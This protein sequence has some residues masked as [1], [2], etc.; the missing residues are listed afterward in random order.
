[1][2]FRYD[3]Y[4]RDY[5]RYQKEAKRDA[6]RRK[7]QKKS[8][9][10]FLILKILLVLALV[11]GTVYAVWRWR[12][13]PSLPA[14]QVT[15]STSADDSANADVSAEPEEQ[16]ADQAAD[17]DHMKAEEA[18]DAAL[19]ESGKLGDYYIEITGATLDKDYYGN[20]IIIVSFTW[21]NNSDETDSAWSLFGKEAF[22]DGVELDSATMLKSGTMDTK[23]NTLDVKPGA[24]LEVQRAYI[25]RNE[26]SPVEFEI[27]LLFD[28][29]DDT[30]VSATFDIQ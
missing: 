4:K 15:V 7:R 10:V 6:K 29:D 28:W 23:A 9:W 22:Q 12:G 20:D 16:E 26:E 30:V 11:V 27:S 14:L 2:A 19:S 24:S 5:D 21:T 13:N 8:Y 25:L 18:E 1:M 17:S 3:D